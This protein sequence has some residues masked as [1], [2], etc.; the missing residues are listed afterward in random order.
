MSEPTRVAVVHYHA[1]PG[2]VTSV[3]RDLYRD[4]PHFDLTWLTGEAPAP[5]LAGAF[6]FLL[7][8]E[9]TYPLKTPPNDLEAWAQ[10]IF[11]EVVKTFNGNPPDVWHLHNHSLGKNPTLLYFANWLSHGGFPT[12]LQIHDFAEDGRPTNF[13]DRSTWTS[14]AITPYPL[15][16][17]T[18]YAVLNQRDAGFLTRAG[19][20]R[21]RLHVLPNPIP[22]A[23]STSGPAEVPASPSATKQRILYPVRALARKNLA[24]IIF[25]ALHADR[26]V[27]WWSTLGPSQESYRPTFEHWQ[28]LARSVAPQVKFG[29]VAAGE[30]SFDEAYA[31]ATAVVN[32][33]VNEGFGLAFLEPWQRGKAL[34]GRN[35]PAI[36]ADFSQSGISLPGL[37]PSLPIPQSWLRE[38]WLQEDLAATLAATLVPYGIEI[39]PQARSP[40]LDHFMGAPAVDFGQLSPRLQTH[41]I[42]HCSASGKRL[43]GLDPLS[44][45]KGPD[46]STTITANQAEVTR[47]YA[48]PVRRKAL[49]TL[50]LKVM[51]ERFPAPS[52]PPS[53]E[54]LIADFLSPNRL[55]LLSH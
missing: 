26:G 12:L 30:C 10:G 1:R 51:Q 37:Y 28:N 14:G 21:E 3:V 44:G 25:L 18:Q 7:I 42:E 35:L 2:G 17:Q 54:S 29:V 8:P 13:T 38:D 24:E 43:D 19:L 55:I 50:Y 11:Q 32:T 53:P 6:R 31:S 15:G 46:L 39:T 33:S 41:V 23:S 36:T 9:L 47:S 16:A 40:F 34:V 20:P 45:L 5:D 49:V 27:D 48:P 4:C 52:A 22:S